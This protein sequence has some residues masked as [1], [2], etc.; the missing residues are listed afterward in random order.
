MCF[1]LKQK[2]INRIQTNRMD[3]HSKKK[4]NWKF[5]KKK[6]AYQQIPKTNLIIEKG[7]VGINRDEIESTKKKNHLCVD[8]LHWTDH[9]HHFYQL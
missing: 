3:Q 7:H 9:R 1:P 8:W 2:S 4:K 6:L 5:Q